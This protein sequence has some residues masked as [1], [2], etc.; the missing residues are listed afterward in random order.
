V[1]STTLGNIARGIA[2]TTG[3]GSLGVSA[4]AVL[5]A[6]SPGRA[7][8]WEWAALAGLSVATVLVGSL[9]LAL[10]Y[11]L[12]KLEI[13]MLGKEAELAAELRKMRLDMH[14]AVLAK[15][16][17][18]LGVGQSF[19]DLILADS[20]HLS[21]EQNGAILGVQA[22]QRRPRQA[23]G[24]GKAP[25]N[26]MPGRRLHS[27]CQPSGSDSAAGGDHAVRHQ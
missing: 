11:A 1:E 24:P 21:V 23:R 5:H 27:R 7:P 26:A 22:G 3:A 12:G 16:A 4:F 25:P 8:V 6:A 13:Q 18:K 14:R 10:E 20:I 2:G 17:D 9:G 19:S 15:A